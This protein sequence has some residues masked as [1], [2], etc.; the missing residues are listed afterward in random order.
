M[1]LDDYDYK[2]LEDALWKTVA[3][4]ERNDISPRGNNCF[5]FKYQDGM[6]LKAADELEKRENIQKEGSGLLFQQH[7]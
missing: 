2:K 7:F 5:Y 1:E 3:E 6:P 4:T